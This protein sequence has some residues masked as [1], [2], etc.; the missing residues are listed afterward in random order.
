LSFS[1]SPHAKACAQVGAPLVVAALGLGLTAM[2]CGIGRPDLDGASSSGA[3]FGQVARS[4]YDAGAGAATTPV[5]ASLA[6]QT[7]RPQTSRGRDLDCLAEAVYYEARGESE[8]GQAAVAQVVL[9]RARHPNYPKSVCGV[10]FQGG[11]AGDC[12][13]SF[14]CDG[15]MSRPVEPTAW[16]QARQIAARAL[17]GYV[18]TSVGRA[19]NFHVS[20]TGAERHAAPGTVA[21]L[22]RHVFFVAVNRP[23][24]ASAR[25]GEPPHIMEASLVARAP[26]APEAART[27]ALSEV[28]PSKTPRPGPTE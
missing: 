8:A 23:G 14:V 27:A 6:Q 4:G 15:A 7:A 21:Q 10:V 12:Q 2:I 13:F 1:L 17:S 5:A 16:R 24:A 20:P 9:N 28:T 18:M 26:D 19:L 25:R 22:G 3:A 11:F